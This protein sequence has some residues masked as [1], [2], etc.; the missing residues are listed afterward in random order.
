MYRQRYAKGIHNRGLFEYMLE[1][2]RLEQGYFTY[3]RNPSANP[4]DENNVFSR[5]LETTRR[6]HARSHSAGTLQEGGHLML[7]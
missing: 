5:M 7:P 3:T 2:A 6:E 4:L 1:I